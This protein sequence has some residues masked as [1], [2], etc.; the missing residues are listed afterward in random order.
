MLQQ[1]QK[2]IELICQRWWGFQPSN[3]HARELRDRLIL[4]GQDCIQTYM[5]LILIYI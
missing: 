5:R 4:G 3:L 1:K 2:F